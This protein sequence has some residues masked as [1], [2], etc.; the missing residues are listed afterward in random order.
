MAKEALGVEK[1]CQQCLKRKPTTRQRSLYL[2]NY[3]GPCGD[4]FCYAGCDSSSCKPVTMTVC[5]VCA[6]KVSKT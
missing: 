1:T 5:D 3:M 2:K 4:S 6:K